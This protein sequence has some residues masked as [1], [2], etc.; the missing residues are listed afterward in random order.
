[1]T[2][3]LEPKK[4]FQRSSVRYTACP[5]EILA[6]HYIE[7]T[8]KCFRDGYMYNKAKHFKTAFVLHVTAANRPALSQKK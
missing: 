5:V 3:E 4:T 1:M 6:C 7:N 8:C 2:C